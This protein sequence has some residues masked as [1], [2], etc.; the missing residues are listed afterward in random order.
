MRTRGQTPLVF[1]FGH[2]HLSSLL[3]R[4]HKA[5]VDRR[6]RPLTTASFR[7]PYRPPLLSPVRRLSL[8][9]RDLLPSNR[10]IDEGRVRELPDND[11]KLS[12]ELDVNVDELDAYQSKRCFA[13]SSLKSGIEINSKERGIISNTNDSNGL[14]GHEISTKGKK[15]TNIVWHK[16][17]VEK[18]DR[19]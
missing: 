7:P 3:L 19:Q 2:D 17:S 11:A 18:I 9:T 5:I 6:C 12:S 8:S 4:P 1:S 15:S 10:P 14:I 13:T 16:C